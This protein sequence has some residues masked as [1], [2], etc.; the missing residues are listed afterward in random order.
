MPGI[1]P[2]SVGAEDYKVGQPV[3]WYVNEREI[4]PYV[5]V[6]TEIAPAS[7]KVYVEWPVGGNQ[8][9][10]P[11]DLIIVTKE[12]GESPI[13]KETGYS[14]YEKEKS[15]KNFG[16]FSPKSVKKLAEKLAAATQSLDADE[17]RTRKMASNIARKFASDVV[18][19]LAS[20][21]LDC[22]KE[23][24]SDIEAYQT[25]YANYEDVCSDQFLRLAIGKIY[26]G[27]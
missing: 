6:I 24:L 22:R 4:S 23:G 2:H 25:V 11:T 20:D 14:S 16:E 13:K 3:K 17:Y 10:D 1:F 26:E 5:G 9:M 15:K 18:E 12:Q 8:Q 7:N 27:E 19:K 21:V